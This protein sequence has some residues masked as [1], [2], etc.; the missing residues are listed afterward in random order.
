MP[1][2]AMVSDATNPQAQR[3]PCF[4]KVTEFQ[5]GLSPGASIIPYL[6]PRRRFYIPSGFTTIPGWP[7]VG[8]PSA[9]IARPH[10]SP[11]VDRQQRYDQQNSHC[12]ENI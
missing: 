1:P 7:D 9:Q 8:R 4:F 12:R 6:S 5:A 3:L 11:D 10:S 2:V